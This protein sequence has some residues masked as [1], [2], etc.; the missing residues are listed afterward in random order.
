[1]EV[2]D[3]KRGDE[4]TR[5]RDD[6]AT[7]WPG[8]KWPG[9]EM[10]G[11]KWKG[12]NRGV[13]QNWTTKSEFNVH[14]LTQAVRKEN[15]TETF[16]EIPLSNSAF[17][18]SPKFIL[19]CVI[20]RYVLFLLFHKSLFKNGIRV[21]KLGSE[22]HWA[23]HVATNNLC[24]IWHLIWTAKKNFSKV[25]SVVADI[26]SFRLEPFNELLSVQFAYYRW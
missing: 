18:Q 24:S 19:K 13:T 3:V 9:Y 6:Q 14:L 22:S 7:K 4:M 11:M 5:G 1:M 21:H 20:P 8:T 2:D 12:T 17:Y 15:K 25:G 23:L 10:T 16:H 26:I